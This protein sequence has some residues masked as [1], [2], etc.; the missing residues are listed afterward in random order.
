MDFLQINDMSSMFF[1]KQ[2]SF[3]SFVLMFD[4]IIILITPEMHTNTKFR[5]H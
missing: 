4:V 3:F 5:N 1:R 2:L